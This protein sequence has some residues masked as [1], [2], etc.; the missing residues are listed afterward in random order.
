MFGVGRSTVYRA[1]ERQRVQ[2]RA[3]LAEASRRSF[4]T[5]G[6]GCPVS[7]TPAGWRRHVGSVPGLRAARGPREHLIDDG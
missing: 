1:I 4:P 3:G 6:A 2:A 5:H 7:G